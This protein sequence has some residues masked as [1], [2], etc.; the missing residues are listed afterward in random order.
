MHSKKKIKF[1]ITFE[2][3]V[4]FALYLALGIRAQTETVVPSLVR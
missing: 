1:A 2:D 3:L 4:V